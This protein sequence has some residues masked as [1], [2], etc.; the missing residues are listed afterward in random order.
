MGKRK[1]DQNATWIPRKRKK[2]K[3]NP[4]TQLKCSL[5]RIFQS[6]PADHFDIGGKWGI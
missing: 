3:V 4:I 6:Y 2:G 5:K 1:R